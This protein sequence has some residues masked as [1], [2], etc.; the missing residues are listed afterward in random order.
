VPKV[1]GCPAVDPMR[2]LGADELVE[3]AAIVGGTCDCTTLMLASF[4]SG[5]D[6]RYTRNGMLRN[7]PEGGRSEFWMRKN[8]A[9]S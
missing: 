9:A 5:P 6:G 8:V 1:W 3:P 4:A 2:P 7:W